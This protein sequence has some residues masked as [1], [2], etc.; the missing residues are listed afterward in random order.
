[1]RFLAGLVWFGLLSLGAWA[2]EEPVLA[3]VAG[4]KV[5][6]GQVR[7]YVKKRP[8]LAGYLQTGYAGW[9]RVLE[10]LIALRLLNLEGERLKIPREAEDDEDL[11]AFRVK[12]KLL[13]PC[14]P[15]DEKEARRFYQAHPELFSTPVF[16]RLS[17]IE[18]PAS[19]QIGGQPAPAFLQQTAEA[20]RAGKVSLQEMAR[21]CPQGNCLQDLGF[22][23]LDGLEDALLNPL[24]DA[25]PGAVV[26]PIPLGEFVF[27]YQVT[28][29]RE[30]ILAPWEQV[31]AEVPAA[32]QRFCRQEAFVR[33]MHELHRRYGV[34]LHEETLRALR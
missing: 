30:P 24:K 32:A 31:E 8:L 1:M 2:G 19:V 15:P 22:V 23:R 7:A 29:R 33:L 28:A 5:N 27:L 26:G 16:V 18:L 3:E 10:D 6:L 25:Q 34:V 14:D 13:P 17:R 4:E 9:R 20:V 12:R 11:Y 21:R